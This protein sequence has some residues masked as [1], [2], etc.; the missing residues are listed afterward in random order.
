MI[1]KV[2]SFTLV[3][4]L[5]AAMIFL[6][7]AATGVAALALIRRS[8]EKTDDVRLA[9]QCSRQVRDMLSEQVRSAHSKS[10]LVGLVTNGSR[11]S[12]VDSDD[13][14]S[15]YVGVGIFK[16]DTDVTAIYKALNTYII[17]EYSLDTPT[18][19]RPKV[20]VFPKIMSDEC[21]SFENLPVGLSWYGDFVKPFKVYYEK[22]QPDY[23]ISKPEDKIY[24]VVLEDLVYRAKDGSVQVEDEQSSFENKTTSKIFANLTSSSRKLW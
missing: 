5:V 3:E 13:S 23:D 20:N 14:N 15:N 24:R 12:I 21:L 2:K 11:F 17:R 7:V 19:I 16:N 18:T 8:N 1:K 10:R 4:V 9:D 22:H 6:V